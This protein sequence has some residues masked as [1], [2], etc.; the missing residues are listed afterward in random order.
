MAASLDVPIEQRV[1]EV[2]SDSVLGLHSDCSTAEALRMA[3]EAGVHHFPVIEHDR[4][5]G[6]VCMCDLRHAPPESSIGE[7]MH[8][9]IVEISP[10]ATTSEAAFAMN[11]R[12]VGALLVRDARRVH[13]IVTRRDLVDSEEQNSVLFPEYACSVCGATRHLRA[14]PDGLRLCMECGARSG[15]GDWLAISADD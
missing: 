10:S 8:R 11:E 7:H 3:E 13:G 1:R 2:M 6:F 4:L 15:G 14:G 12:C 9:E 5:V